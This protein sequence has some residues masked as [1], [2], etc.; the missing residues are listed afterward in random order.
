MAYSIR[1]R[2]YLQNNNGLSDSNDYIKQLY[3]KN[4]N[5]DPPPATNTIEDS[6][7][8]FENSQRASIPNFQ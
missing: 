6:I 3:I 2:Y 8:S 7:T 1:T 5:W 4:K